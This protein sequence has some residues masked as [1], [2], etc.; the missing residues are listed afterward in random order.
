[1]NQKGRYHEMLFIADT[2]Q[3]A[4][5]HKQIYSPNIIA[6]GSSKKD[7]NSFSHHSDGDIGVAVIDR[8]TYFTLDYLEKMN[9]NGQD[10]L[11]DLFNDYKQRNLLSNPEYRLVNFTRPFDQVL[12]SEF[13]AEVV[14]YA[15][16]DAFPLESSPS[17]STGK[18]CISS[19]SSPAQSNSPRA[20]NKQRIDTVA[21]KMTT[22]TVVVCVVIVVFAVMWREG[23]EIGK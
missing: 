11:Q 20:S 9:I 14:K 10:R 23:N 13:F 7:E 5:L 22:V 1:M 2:C 12:I 17:L 4:T 19:K 6:I 15:Y 18:D 8:F 16:T 21:S 3:A